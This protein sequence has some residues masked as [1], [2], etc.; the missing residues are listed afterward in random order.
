MYVNTSSK[1]KGD[2]L[3]SMIQSDVAEYRDDHQTKK[4]EDGQPL[5]TKD[6]RKVTVK[7]FLGDNKGNYEAV[8]Y[9][10]EKYIVA[11]LVF[12][13]KDE[14][15]FRKDLP[16]FKE[17]VGSYKFL[18]DNPNEAALSGT[19]LDFVIPADILQTAQKELNTTEGSKYDEKFGPYFQKYSDCMSGEKANGW[20]RIVLEIAKDG[21]PIHIYVQRHDPVNDCLAPKFQKE[22]F[23]PP[24]FA[25]FYYLFELNVTP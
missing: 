6:G 15:L 9:V 17:L 13:T 24:P 10:E 8:A 1:E 11:Y 7:Y 20:H 16:F 23:P 5:T 12:S 2:T 22:K 21:T 25:P 19:P 3:Q 18:T 14:G 4:I